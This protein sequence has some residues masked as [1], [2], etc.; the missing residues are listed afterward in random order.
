MSTRVKFYFSIYLKDK[1]EKLDVNLPEKFL[2]TVKII[3]E[4]LILKK[5]L[6]VDYFNRLLGNSDE[7]TLFLCVS[8]T[9]EEI[10]P[11]STTRSTMKTSKAE[12]WVTHTG[13][14]RKLF[15]N[16]RHS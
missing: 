13:A 15:S 3:K 5:W 14:F 9:H 8:P 4:I 11:S 16:L 12:S 1:G 6:K 2:P 7:N 10:V